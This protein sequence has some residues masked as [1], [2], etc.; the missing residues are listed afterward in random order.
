MIPSIKEMN[1]Q[2][3]RLKTLMGTMFNGLG[4]FTYGE[5]PDY[6]IDSL[7]ADITSVISDLA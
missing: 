2:L 1:E 5:M 6:S 3:D 7:V 4:E